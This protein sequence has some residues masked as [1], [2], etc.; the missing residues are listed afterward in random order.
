MNFV[1][2]ATFLVIAPLAFSSQIMTDC[3]AAMATIGP[4]SGSGTVTCPGLAT[5][6]GTINFLELDFKYDAD[7]GFNQG[8]VEEDHDVLGTN[9]DAFDNLVFVVV[10][11]LNRPHLG[12]KTTTPPTADQLAAIAAGPQITWNYQNATGSAAGATGDFRWIIDFTPS[13]PAAVPEPSTFVLMGFGLVG[14]SQVIRRRRPGR[15]TAPSSG[16]VVTKLYT[17]R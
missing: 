12:S 15:A 16:F 11:D 4:T 6:G 1:L 14:L 10:T 2:V 13:G 3:P 5:P 9:L 8:S 17:N 7:F